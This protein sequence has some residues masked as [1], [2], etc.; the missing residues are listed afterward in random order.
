MSDTQTLC[1]PDILH[2]IECEYREM[3]GLNLT[4]DQ[5][6]RLWGMPRTTVL[7]MF[8]RLVERGVL[9]RNGVGKYLRV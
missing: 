9:R 4:P 3:P 2:R 6:A 5:G 8:D 1:D 7:D